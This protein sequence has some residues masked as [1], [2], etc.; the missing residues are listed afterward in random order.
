M[1]ATLLW[2]WQN[3]Q[4]LQEEPIEL[5]QQ[6]TS[7]WWNAF[8]KEVTLCSIKARAN[9]KVKHSFPWGLCSTRSWPCLVMVAENV[10]KLSSLLKTGRGKA[11]AKDK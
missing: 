4:W 5:L 2:Q 11:A 10:D 1:Q 7:V 6:N 8:Q 9:K 3:F